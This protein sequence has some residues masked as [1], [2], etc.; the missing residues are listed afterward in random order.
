MCTCTNVN[1]KITACNDSTQFECYDS[2]CVDGN[3]VCDGTC[4]C[5][6]GSDENGPACPNSAQCGMYAHA[7]KYIIYII[8]ERQII[9][10]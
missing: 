8:L 2:Q 6:D 10:N 1:K 9:L 3:D 5:A 4:D 7:S